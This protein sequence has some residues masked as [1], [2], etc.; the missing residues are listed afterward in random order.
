MIRLTTPVEDVSEAIEWS[1]A[2]AMSIA[3][4][5]FA[6]DGIDASG[7]EGSLP[8]DRDNYFL[9][10]TNRI[11][12]ASRLTPELAVD[13]LS[14]VNAH[15]EAAAFKELL[16]LNNAAKTL[17]KSMQKTNAVSAKYTAEAARLRKKY[18][19]NG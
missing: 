14:D 13:L 7:L 19:G 12:A 1:I 10:L 17:F 8:E 4:I 11:H 5:A 2:D 18:G 16:D 15:E 3:V 6:N 9:S